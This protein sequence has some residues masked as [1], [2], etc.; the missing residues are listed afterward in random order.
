MISSF[1]QRFL[2]PQEIV[3][4]FNLELGMT[5]ADFGSGAGDF[6]IAAA[7]AVG[8]NGKVYAIDV[9]ESAHQSLRSKARISEVRNIE[10][11]LT[12]LETPSGSTLPEDSV[13]QV[14]IH[15]LLFQVQDKVQI[16]KDAKKI[17][18][19][20]GK[21]N[22]IE[23]D[24]SSPIGPSKN[25]RMSE[26]EITSLLT[27]IGFVLDRRIQAGKYHYGLIYRIQ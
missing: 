12:N 4:Q 16:I 22:I 14:M 17:L 10:M 9:L 6:S 20:T 2:S 26:T 24:L 23:W 13:D 1:S 19:N 27:S 21:V 18:K 7:Q 5:I 3:A 25:S 15:N 11:F 8:S